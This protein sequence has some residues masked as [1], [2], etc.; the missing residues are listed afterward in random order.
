MTKENQESKA[1]SFVTDKEV[2]S[3][4]TETLAITD[5][6]IRVWK[7]M[8]IRALRLT[9]EQDWVSQDGKPYLQ[10]S[11]AERIAKPYGISLL[12]VRREKI[13]SQD[14]GGQYYI[15]IYEGDA[16]MRI[17]GRIVTQH[18]VGTCSS[19]DALYGKSGGVY[20]QL[21]QVDEP[22]V[23]KAAHTNFIVNAITHILGLRNL[24]WDQLKAAGLN[25]DAICTVEHQI[26]SK[27]GSMAKDLS[28]EGQGKLAEV[29]KWG[30]AMNEGD[31]SDA[32]RYFEMIST[33][34]Y[35][36]K[37]SGEKK[38]YSVNDPKKWSEKVLGI[39]HAKI[40]KDF[41][42][43]EKAQGGAND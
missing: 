30:L 3:V 11:G 29:L 20:K 19:R 14:D 41:E 27:G 8:T 28:T 10:H 24:T 35:T 37:K 23:M 25:A 21:S 38:T 31:A 7:E 13:V 16:S 18:A 9:T 42:E 40:K 2:V 39:A 33:F 5:E 6:S 15:Y 17:S 1:L 26:G 4:E 36:D 12:D 34:Q 43:F 32:A 22:S